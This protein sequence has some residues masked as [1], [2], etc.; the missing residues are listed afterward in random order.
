MTIESFSE[1]VNHRFFSLLEDVFMGAFSA[2]REYLPKIRK[3]YESEGIPLLL[4]RI[5]R[6][7]RYA[8]FQTN[9]ALWFSRNLSYPI[10]EIQPRVP[11]EVDW[12][13]SRTLEW[14]RT[15]TPSDIP[16][17]FSHK[18][19]K[20]TKIGIKRRHYFV[21]AKHQ[22]NIIGYVKIG[23][24]EVYIM[25]F[26]MSVYFPRGTALIYDTYIVPDFRGLGVAPFLITDVMRS[27]KER[28][29]QRVLC[30]IRT[31]NLAS[32]SA[33]TKCSF[34]ELKHVW[35]FRLFGKKWFSTH[36]ETL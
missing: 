36:P 28:G 34:E 23:Y 1:T 15:R 14:L 22:G 6:R 11:L 35:Y 16:W 4:V 30:H 10:L 12:D 25:D 29:Y 26:D 3:A 24:G 21:N 20:E 27:L 5:F 7:I 32:I 18:G 33:Y 19:K 9:N 13:F 17:L 31:E 2:V 8:V